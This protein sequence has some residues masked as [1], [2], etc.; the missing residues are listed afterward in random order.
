MG[1]LPEEDRVEASFWPQK[2]LTGFPG[3]SH[4]LLDSPFT[5]MPAVL[6]VFLNVPIAQTT[7]PCCKGRTHC[8]IH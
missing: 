4:V 3:T 5:A 1:T 6:G 7:W 8:C 2:V